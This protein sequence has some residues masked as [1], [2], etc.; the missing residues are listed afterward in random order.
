MTAPAAPASVM[1]LCWR[2]YY[3]TGDWERQ[4]H[5]THW[6]MDLSHYKQL[7]AECEARSGD[8]TDPETWIPDP[9]AMLL[10]IAIDGRADGGEPHLET[11]DAP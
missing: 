4:H 7:R 1:G 8:R 2:A 3:A 6:V 11:P 9:G 10:T 5:L